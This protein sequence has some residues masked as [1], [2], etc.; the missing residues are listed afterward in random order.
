MQKSL[1]LLVAGMA[2]LVPAEVMA[3]N[4]PASADIT[5]KC[6]PS[7]VY[8]RRMYDAGK[9]GEVGM[10][11]SVAA[12]GRT[13]QVEVVASSGFRTLDSAAEIAVRQWQFC[14]RKIGLETSASVSTFTIRFDPA[15]PEIPASS[16]E[17]AKCG[18]TPPTPKRP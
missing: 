7:P 3:E 2:I 1:A 15:G 18:S 13:T 14:P 16:C 12:D 6:G 17:A 5:Y 11:V 9:D 4:L 10:Q 8:P